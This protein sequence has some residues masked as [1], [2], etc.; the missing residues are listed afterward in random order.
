VVA[1][2]LLGAVARPLAFA[3]YSQLMVT[4]RAA[5]TLAGALLVAAALLAAF[6]RRRG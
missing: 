2:H 6:G 5:T 4:V 3:R 1:S